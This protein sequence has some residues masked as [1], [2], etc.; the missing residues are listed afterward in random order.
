MNNDNTIYPWGDNR[1]YN[2]YSGYFNRIF[3]SRVQK[4]TIN[5]GFTCP[6]RDGSKSY[7]GCSF[8]NNSAF[9]PSYCK[10]E[11]SIKQQIEEGKEFHSRRYKKAQ[12]YLAY[13][14]AY[15]NTYKPLDELKKIYDEALDCEDIVGLVIGTRPDCVDEYKLDY[16]AELSQKRYI[17]IEYGVESCYNDTLRRINRGHSFE[18]S[19]KAIEQSAIRGIHVGAHFILGLP[20]ETKEMMIEQTDMIN[21]LKIN[22]IKFHQLQIFKDTIMEKEY[23]QNPSLFNFFEVDEYISLFGEILSRLRE[24]IVIERFAG[25]A[26]PRFHAGPS[27]G[28]IR[29]EA[30]IQKLDKY[31]LEKDIRQGCLINKYK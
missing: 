24:D 31:L 3:G 16:F 23:N 15:S 21:R 17:I 27:W 29:N 2:S 7:G 10:P 6:N 22:T 26:P 8:C 1:R 4:V 12:K 9:N 14:Q 18:D 30:L 28:M 5:A 11:K 19:V 13:F 20:S 25:E